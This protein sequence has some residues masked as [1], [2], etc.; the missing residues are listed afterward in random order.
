MGK[1][2]SLLDRLKELGDP[3]ASR[4]AASTGENVEALLDSVRRNVI[5]LLNARQGMSEAV[6]DYGLPSLTEFPTEREDFVHLVQESVRAAI[7]KYEPRLRRVRV[8]RAE[9]DEESP[10]RPAFRIEAVLVGAGGEHRVWYDTDLDGS[11]SFRV[12]E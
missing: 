4:R 7:T 10:R 9:S 12:S 3:Y 1:E 2:S 6:P 8:S 11:G 5:R